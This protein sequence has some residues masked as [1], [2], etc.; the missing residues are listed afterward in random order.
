M[1]DRIKDIHLPPTE[2]WVAW[3]DSLFDER[4]WK[5]IE[6]PKQ[7]GIHGPPLEIIV[8]LL[9]EAVHVLRRN[10]EHATQ[11]HSNHS[12]TWMLM[13]VRVSMG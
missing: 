6:K 8:Q 4:R 13:R 7:A 3:S 10:K 2:G 11:N 1:E 5:E 12:M 9:Y